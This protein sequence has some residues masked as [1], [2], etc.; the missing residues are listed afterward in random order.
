MYRHV[1]RCI[2]LASPTHRPLHT[3]KLAASLLRAQALVLACCGYRRTQA[4]SCRC[5]AHHLPYARHRSGGAASS[6]L[7]ATCFNTTVTIA[8]SLHPR[9]ST[10]VVPLLHLPWP[11]MHSVHVV[12]LCHRHHH[13]NVQPAIPYAPRA[14]PLH[15]KALPAP[16]CSSASVPSPPLPPP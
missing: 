16:C 15:R 8:S 7:A 12:R 14:C 6:E 10:H 4:D 2:R 13:R 11:P 1:R 9:P 3:I 5:L